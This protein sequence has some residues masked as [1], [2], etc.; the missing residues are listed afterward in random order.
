[1]RLFNSMRGNIRARVAVV[2]LTVSVG[3]FGA[4]QASEGFNPRPHIPTKG[5]VPTIGHGST[6]YE[7][8]LSVKLTDAPISRQ[9][10]EQLARNLMAADEAQFRASLPGVSLYPEEYDLYM[11][12]VGQYGIGR[13]R[14]STMR[15]ELLVGNY[16]AACDALLLYRRQ[17]GRDCSRPENWG[18]QGCKGVW[19][20]QLQRHQKC[21]AVQ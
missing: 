10:A 15:R 17:G 21:M 12:F 4:W 16:R 6:R 9:R 19:T 3:G 1:M 5:D 20:R 7:N 11:D 8:G 13:W 2:L 18:P 14:D